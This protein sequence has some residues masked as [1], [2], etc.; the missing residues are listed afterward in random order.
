MP[1]ERYKEAILV[2][3]LPESDLRA[4]DVGTV[5]EQHEVPGLEI[6]YSVEFFDMTGRTVTVVTVSASDLRSPTPADRPTVRT[7]QSQV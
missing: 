5:V 1:I 3:D 4:G 2:R 7:L 6:G